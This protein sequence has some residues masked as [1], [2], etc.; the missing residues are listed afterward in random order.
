MHRFLDCIDQLDLS[1]V[2]TDHLSYPMTL[3][4]D[5]GL[6]LLN[7][8][9]FLHPLG[10]KESGGSRVDFL[11]HGSQLGDDLIIRHFHWKI[12]I[13]DILQLETDPTRSQ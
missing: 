5:L 12:A 4:V 2:L 1:T 9:E 7:G 8:G 3:P 13:M 11:F 6:D 10:Q